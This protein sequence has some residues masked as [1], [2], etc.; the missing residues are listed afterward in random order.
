MESR[1]GGDNDKDRHQVREYCARI[2]VDP[3]RSVPN[4]V[5]TS[6]YHRALL[7]KLHVWRDRGPNET[8]EEENVIRISVQLGTK[9]P[10]LLL[11]NEDEP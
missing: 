10:S 6:F 11:P 9:A 5:T 1:G 7:E 3:L 4:A 2:H 8:Y